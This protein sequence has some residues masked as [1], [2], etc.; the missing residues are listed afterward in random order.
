MLN[1]V[2]T[3]ILY[4]RVDCSIKGAGD[5]VKSAAKTVKDSANTKNVAKAACAAATVTSSLNAGAAAAH[6]IANGATKK[7]V[8]SA[9]V[10]TAKAVGFNSI[11][12]DIKNK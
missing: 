5:K 9:V 6:I 8:A 12:K 7:A 4:S 10:N 11:R 2:K 1:K 3:S